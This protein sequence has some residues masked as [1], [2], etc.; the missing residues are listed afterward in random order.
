MII[1]L[2]TSMNTLIKIS[3]NPIHCLR[4]NITAGGILNFRRALLVS[5]FDYVQKCLPRK[6]P[7]TNQPSERLGVRKEISRNARSP[8]RSYERLFVSFKTM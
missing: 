8:R 6:K 5:P 7:I 4:S 2:L 1:I 3:N